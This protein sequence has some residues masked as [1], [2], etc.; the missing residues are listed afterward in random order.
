[1]EDFL[2]RRDVLE[3]KWLLQVGAAPGMTRADHQRCYLGPKQVK[4]DGC[5]AGIPEPVILSILE[6][7]CVRLS[8]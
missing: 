7:N 1:M 6:R 4:H 8:R 3:C 2:F 5:S